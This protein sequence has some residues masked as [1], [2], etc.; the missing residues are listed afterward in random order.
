MREADGI[1]VDR[2]DLSREI[3]IAEIPSV[4]EYIQYCRAVSIP[5]YIATNVLDCMMRASLP[6]RSEISDIYHLLKSGVSGLV[7]AAEA[8]IGDNPIDSTLVLNYLHKYYLERQTYWRFNYR[9]GS[10]DLKN[11]LNLPHHIREWL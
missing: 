3:S 5:T 9:S 10:N 4:V 7:L 8:A 6:S 2:G 1:L 11:S